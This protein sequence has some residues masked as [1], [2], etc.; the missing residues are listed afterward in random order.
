MT[1][2]NKTKTT[3]GSFNLSDSDNTL[4]LNC[5]LCSRNGMDPNIVGRNHV[6]KIIK[7]S[8]R[9]SRY[10]KEKGCSVTIDT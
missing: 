7:A 3:L 6:A 8:P 4:Q 10:V 5:T 1:M 2:T 9:V